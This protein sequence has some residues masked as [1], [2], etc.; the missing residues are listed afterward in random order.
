MDILAVTRIQE[1]MKVT[2]FLIL[3]IETKNSTVNALVGL[4]Q[5]LTY[6][7]KSLSEQASVSDY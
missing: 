7:Y 3:L 2:P 5:L 4:P 6:A 1:K